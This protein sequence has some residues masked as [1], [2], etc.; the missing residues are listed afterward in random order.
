MANNYFSRCCLKI[1]IF[2]FHL[3]EAILKVKSTKTVAKTAAKNTMTLMLKKGYHGYFIKI[4]VKK[5][6]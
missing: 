2:G 6:K 4:M 5:M 3:L 1:C